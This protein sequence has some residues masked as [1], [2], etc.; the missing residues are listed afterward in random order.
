M[1]DWGK[2]EWGDGRWSVYTFLGP[3][4]HKPKHG[5][6]PTIA[7]SIFKHVVKRPYHTQHTLYNKMSTMNGVCV[8]VLISN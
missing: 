6:G 7:V 5:A 8:C 2:V 3:G 1:V 4:G